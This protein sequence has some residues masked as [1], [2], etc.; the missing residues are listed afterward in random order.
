LLCKKYGRQV[1]QILCLCG[2]SKISQTAWLAGG[3]YISCFW[4]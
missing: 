3:W 1:T 4:L 2:F